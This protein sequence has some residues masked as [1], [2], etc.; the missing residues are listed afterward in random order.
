MFLREDKLFAVVWF[1]TRT[2]CT[3]GL[4]M[5]GV[6]R[7]LALVRFACF[8]VWCSTSKTHARGYSTL[9]EPAGCMRRVLLE[10]NL[11]WPRGAAHSRALDEVFVL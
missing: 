8:L 9:F 2:F 5:S 3:R 11:P 1:E 10:G 7:G 6:V 4:R